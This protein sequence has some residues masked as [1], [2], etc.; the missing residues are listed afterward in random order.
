MEE[1]KR[2]E[3]AF[4]VVWSVERGADTVDEPATKENARKI[5]EKRRVMETA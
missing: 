2:E 3:D 4:I 5:G 1:R